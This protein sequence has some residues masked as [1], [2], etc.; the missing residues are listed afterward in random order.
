MRALQEKKRILEALSAK[1]ALIVQR[2][3]PQ[4]VQEIEE[5]LHSVVKITAE[6]NWPVLTDQDKSVDQFIRNFELT[7]GCAN[8]GKGMKRS[9]AL[10]VLGQCLRGSRLQV[11]HQILTREMMTRTVPRDPEEE[12][13][14]ILGRLREFAE[15]QFERQS[16][17]TN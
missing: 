17:V 2:S 9:D 5:H 11:Y 1:T 6:I 3:S 7:I 4:R 15:G 12:Y 14:E 16:K 10:L 13:Q 8:E